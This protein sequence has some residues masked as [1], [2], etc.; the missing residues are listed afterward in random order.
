[1]W[2]LVW[3]I[4]KLELRLVASHPDGVGGL[5]F[6]EGTVMAMAPIVLASSVVLAG[7]WG[8]EVLYHGVHVDSLKPL[9][10]VFTVTAVLFFNGPLFLLGRNLRAFKRKS[11]LEYST[12]VGNHGHLV[13]QRWIRRQDIG[14]PDIL[15][16]P[17]LGPT[18]DISSIY[19][20]VAKM[21]FAPI[22][23]RSLLPIAI[24]AL[25]PCCPCSP[26]RFQSN[27]CS[28]RWLELFCEKEAVE[29]PVTITSPRG[30]RPTR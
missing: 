17:E 23:K 9:V 10:A 24:A 20:S 6:I 5:A 18:V 21:R 4:S 14:A 7:R 11:L 15:N 26:S 13:Y 28:A 25:L 30:S 19:E 29:D 1:M 27:K 12:L 3:K 16:A 22:G 8:H 2:T